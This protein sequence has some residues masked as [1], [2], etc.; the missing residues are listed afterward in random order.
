MKIKVIALCVL[1]L[2]S[3]VSAYAEIGN[4]KGR[5]VDSKTKMAIEYATVSIQDAE[6]KAFVSGTVSDETGA[7]QIGNLKP[8]TFV[9]R[10][11]TV[12]YA[13]LE[14]EFSIANSSSNINLHTLSLQEDSQMLDEVEVVGQRSQMRFE[15][16]KRVFN[17]DQSLATTGGSASDVL[18]NIPSV[19][20]DTEGEISL[21][22]NSSVTIWINGRASGLSA[23]NR[24]QI[25][26]QLPA[27]SI[28]RVEVITNPSARYNP[29]GT[30]GIIN[31]ILK[32]DRKGGYYGS[33][34][35]G[36]DTRGGYNTG[37][38]VN[39]SS[40]KLDAFVNIGHRV[41]KGK[42]KG[43]TFRDNLDEEG[44]VVSFLNQQRRDKETQWPFFGRAGM[45]YHLTSKDHISLSAFGLVDNEEED[46]MMD[47]SSNVPGSY[48][49]SFRL[50]ADKNNMKMGNFELNY[51]RDFHEK[52]NLDITVSRFMMNREATP[53]YTQNS[54]YADG[55]ETAS[56]QSQTSNSKSRSWEVQ[57][58]YTNE[59][60]GENKVEAG[61]K[62]NIN[63]RKSPVETYS[64]STKE[65]AVF[66]EQLY[67]FFR[68]NQ[69]VHA[70]YT[71]YSKR[72][73]DFGVQLGLRGEY[74]RMDTRSLGYGQTESDVDLYKDDYFS[75]Y[76]TVFLSYALPKGNEVQLNYTRR[77]SRPW[78]GQL[79]P[80]RNVMD[81][82]NISYGNPYLTPQYSNSLELNYI[83]NWAE[84]TLSTSLYYRNTNNVIQRINYL[85]NNIM[86]STYE[87][88]AKTESAGA[89]F[90]VKNNLWKRL[91]LTSSLNFYYNKLDAFSYLP[92]GAEK[93][94]T[95]KANDDFSW[96][97]RVTANILLPYQVSF[98][99][100][101]RYNSKQIIAQGYNKAN[102]TL[103]LGVRKSFLRRKLNLTV[104][105]R[106]ILDSRK[107]TTITSGSGFNQENVFARAGRIIG[108]TLTYSFG[109]M[110]DNRKRSERSNDFMQENGGGEEL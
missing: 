77:V 98:Q 49:N 29:E 23:D 50:S 4:L 53:T 1:F 17:V 6:T 103:D 51:K 47:Y 30:A 96:S 34:Q 69:D 66:D 68:Y 64:G 104:S 56:Y 91:D 58:D 63:R 14:K 87:N 22:G 20:V 82:T 60:G 97:G 21:R 93:T 9:A 16:D 12:G 48:I 61:Y 19:E 88:V 89:E 45:T 76:P 67:N 55:S 18:G 101:G 85:E 40:G 108:F 72:F 92:P 43:H 15:I 106:D 8:G 84:H 28:E 31:I 46:D 110:S 78:G 86:M 107:R 90:I 71:T 13:P 57:A 94:V 80:F 35:A 33:V 26:E 37:G 102:G 24:A 3:V 100:T 62:G 95:G 81:S 54:T 41:R 70:L 59:F 105:A 32:K 44:N 79:N 73:N 7:F 10:I 75:I 83:R 109:N 42:G 27:E 99:A 65:T 2:F 5:I 52:S 36:V 74:T 38:N 25:L 11:T 39:Y